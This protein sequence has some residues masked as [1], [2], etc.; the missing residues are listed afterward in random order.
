MVKNTW[1]HT[2]SMIIAY[3][4]GCFEMIYLMA[5]VHSYGKMALNTKVNGK[6]ASNK[7]EEYRPC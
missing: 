2:H 7:E 4:Q 6:M 1:V 5:Q 3:I